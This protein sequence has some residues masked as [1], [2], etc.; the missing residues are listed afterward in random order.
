MTT[1]IR[2]NS[3]ARDRLKQWCWQKQCD[4][5]ELIDQMI[6]Y[7]IRKKQQAFYNSLPAPSTVKG[8][9]INGFAENVYKR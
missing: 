3:T 1:T 4:M 6:E 2:V 9:K 5:P 8:R 7:V